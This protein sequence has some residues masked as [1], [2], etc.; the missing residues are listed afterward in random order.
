MSLYNVKTVQDQYRI[1]KFSDDLD[2]E[3]SYLTSSIACDC[4]A[5]HR[6]TCRHR[7]MLSKFEGRADSP[8]FYDYDNERWYYYHARTAKMMNGPPKP[9][10]RRL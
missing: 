9:S 3:S 7:K 10:W 6:D 2:V 5:G 8:W 1:T 4:P